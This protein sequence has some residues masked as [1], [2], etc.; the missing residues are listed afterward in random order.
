MSG[1]DERTTLAER[2]YIVASVVHDGLT[3][4]EAASKFGRSPATIH[5]VMRQAGYKSVRRQEWQR[6]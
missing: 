5:A 3:I 6:V 4:R 2:R 1:S